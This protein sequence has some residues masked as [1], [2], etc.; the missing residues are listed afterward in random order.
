MLRKNLAGSSAVED[1]AVERVLHLPYVSGPVRL[2][3]DVASRR[4][5][6]DAA[7]HRAQVDFREHL[8]ILAPFPERGN[9]DDDV[10]YPVEKVKPEFLRRD[11]RFEVGVRCENEPRIRFRAFRRADPAEFPALDYVKKRPLHSEAHVPD[12]VEEKRSARCRAEYPLALADFRERSRLDA[13]KLALAGGIDDG[14]HVHAEKR[15]PAPGRY[16]VYPFRDERFAASALAEDEDG[17]IRRG[18]ELDFPPYRFHYFR[19]ADDSEPS[20]EAFFR[21]V[22]ADDACP[23]RWRAESPEEKRLSRF[24]EFVPVLAERKRLSDEK[25]PVVYPLKLVQVAA[26]KNRIIGGEQVVERNDFL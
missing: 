19:G 18:G 26:Y 15:H 8:Y 17:K 12:F 22:L 3:Q 14:R 25:S 13:E 11:F 6:R 10:R 24:E 9:F 23:R 5:Q 2:S 7:S 21:D 4:G 16:F 1:C 20:I